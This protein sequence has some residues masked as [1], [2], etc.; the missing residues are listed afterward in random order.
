MD[1]LKRALNGALEIL[2]SKAKHSVLP[3]DEQLMNKE[4]E[5]PGLHIH[6]EANPL[7]LH[8]HKAGDPM[9]GPHTHTPENPAGVHVHGDLD[10]QPLAD[11]AHFHKD[12]GLGGHRHKEENLGVTPNVRKPGLT[13]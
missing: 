11:G 6:D 12:G 2:K 3:Q 4:S 10:G 1:I 5:G 7:G 13:I 8:A 9:S